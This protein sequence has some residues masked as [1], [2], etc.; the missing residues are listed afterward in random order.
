MNRKMTRAL[1]AILLL[2]TFVA[3]FLLLTGCDSGEGGDEK[4]KTAVSKVFIK[5]F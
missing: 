1:V 4:D 5:E 3:A 2:S